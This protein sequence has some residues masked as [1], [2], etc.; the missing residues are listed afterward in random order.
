MRNSEIRLR[1][2]KLRL[3]DKRFAN[4]KAP[5][6]AIWQQPLQSV[7]ALRGCSA[8]DFKLLQNLMCLKHF[9]ISIL[10]LIL[11]INITKTDRKIELEFCIIY[12]DG[13]PVGVYDECGIAAFVY[14]L[15]LKKYL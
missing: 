10:K 6:T 9:Q 1:K 3:K 4:H 12:L 14:L 7:L 8:T 13:L 15:R 5:C 2:L 11:K